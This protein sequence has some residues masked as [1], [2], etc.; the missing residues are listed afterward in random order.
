MKDTIKKN[1]ELDNY[2]VLTEQM[3]DDAPRYD[4]K[5]IREYCKKHNK[6]LADF[7]EEEFNQFIST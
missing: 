3:P 1:N 7:T 6:S 5:K 2:G 4:F